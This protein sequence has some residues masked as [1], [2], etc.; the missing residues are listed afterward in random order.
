MPKYFINKLV[1]DKYPK[2]FEDDNQ[3]AEIINLTDDELRSELLKKIAE[4]LGEINLKLTRDE[5]ISELADIKQVI[6]DFERLSNISDSEVEQK[7]VKKEEKFG[8]FANGVYVNTL[9][10]S[11]DDK[12]NDYYRKNPEL[13]PEE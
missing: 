6:T 9:E 4:E 3:R 13:Y 10:L 2:I 5:M 11:D 12:W 7:R 8:G 1:R